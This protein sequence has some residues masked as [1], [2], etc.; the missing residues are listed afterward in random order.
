MKPRK[1][2]KASETTAAIITIITVDIET[3]SVIFILK[4]TGKRGV[5]KV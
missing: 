2:P 4:L 3:S 5:K 1:E